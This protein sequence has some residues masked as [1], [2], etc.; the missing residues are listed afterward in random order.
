M[1]GSFYSSL[2]GVGILLD[3]SV[4]AFVLLPTDSLEPVDKVSFYGVAT[5]LASFYG[6]Y[7][8]IF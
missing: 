2:R 5:D 8:L 6:F 3:F 4:S 1:F 7:K